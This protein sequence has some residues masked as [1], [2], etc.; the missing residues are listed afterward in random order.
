MSFN[1]IREDITNLKVDATVNAANRDLLMG[2][3][4]CGAI[5]KVA[6]GKRTPRGL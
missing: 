5:F 2:G 6:R 4:V 1:I 3:G